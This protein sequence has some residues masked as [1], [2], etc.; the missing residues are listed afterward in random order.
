MS[1]DQNVDSTPSEYV[2]DIEGTALLAKVRRG[3][4]DI[5]NS[6]FAKENV[7][8]IIKKINS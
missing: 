8:D 4:D 1:G 5:K 2:R 6:R 3:L 7:L